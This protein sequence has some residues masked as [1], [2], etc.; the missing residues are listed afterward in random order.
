MKITDN[1]GIVKGIQQMKPSNIV[2]P[3]KPTNNIFNQTL[4]SSNSTLNSSSSTNNAETNNNDAN[5][6]MSSSTSSNKQEEFNTADVRNSLDRKVKYN[7]NHMMIHTNNLSNENLLE[8]FNNNKNNNYQ[9]QQQTIHGI[10]TSGALIPPPYRDPPPPINS[11]PLN[12]TNNLQ[13]MQKI[14]NNKSL[15]NNLLNMNLIFNN[16]NDI[17]DLNDVLLN[18]TAQ[19]RDLIQLIKYQRDKINI[20]QSDL[21]KVSIINEIMYERN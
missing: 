14:D 5:M 6:S 18:N 20:Q 16:I 19:Y 10:S 17:N 13:L 8:I 7:N 4:N 9:P 11:S 15:N 12:I 2:S 1:I 21:T 3:Q